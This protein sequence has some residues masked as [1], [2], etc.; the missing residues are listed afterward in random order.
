VATARATTIAVMND[1]M[2][3]DKMTIAMI[4]GAMMI[5]A[6]IGV[7]MT[8]LATTVAV[9]EEDVHQQ[10]AV[11]VDV[12]DAALPLGLMSPARFVIEK[13]I[14]PKIVG[15]GFR[16]LMILLMRH[17][18]MVLTPIGTRIL[19]LHTISRAS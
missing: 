10:E 11:V 14:Q 9:A 1:A 6:K 12:V 8:V 15:T 19:E 3:T 13:G 16:M 2:M 7:K 17:M 4:T 5:D 18:H